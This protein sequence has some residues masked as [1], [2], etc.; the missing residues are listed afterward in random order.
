MSTKAIRYT[1]MILALVSVGVAYAVQAPV[2]A[3]ACKADLAKRLNITVQEVELSKVTPTVFPD[4]SL[5]LARPDEAYAQVQTP[6]FSLQLQAKGRL[7]L[8]TAT[9]KYFRYGGSLDS[10]R[11]SALYIEPVDHDANGNGNL[12]QVSLAGTNPLLILKG[13]DGFRPQDDGSILATRRTSRSGYALLYVAPGK[14]ETASTLYHAFYVGE[15]ALNPDTQQWAAIMR[16]GLGG[17]WKIV[18]NKLGATQKDAVIRDLPADGQPGGIAWDKGELMVGVAKG[19]YTQFYQWTKET[20]PGW[21]KR[22]A[23]S[24]PHASNM[25]LNK[26]QTLVVKTE[27]VKG[28]PVTRIVKRWFTGSEDPV[29]TINNFTAR[30]SVLVGSTGVVLISGV[31]DDVVCAFSV[32]LHTGEVMQTVA[33]AQGVVR[34]FNMP[35]YSWLQLGS[36]SRLLIH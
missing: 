9:T 11:A 24:P 5:G 12:V 34:L 21:S 17:G 29:A 23:Y 32:D 13:V 22:E 18:V 7:Y 36:S 26:S 25:M 20:D 30:E 8:Y 2:T 4:A 16:P 27:Q 6:G 28:R 3:P 35:P 33:H 31:R 15:T 1:L 10:W 14:C 19:G